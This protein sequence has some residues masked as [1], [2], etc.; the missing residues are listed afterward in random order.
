MTTTT[1]PHTLNQQYRMRF[2]NM[3]NYRLGVWR[4]LCSDYFS[5]LVRPTDAVLDLGAGWCEFI[6]TIQ[7][8]QKWAMDLNPDLQRHAGPNVQ[9]ISQDCSASWP[10]PE[11]SLDAVFTS[12]FF[13]HLPTKTHLEATLR[14][15]YRTLK[16]GGVLICMGPNIRY[17]VGAYWDFWDHHVALTDR[18]LCEVLRLTGFEIERSIARFLPYSMSTGWTPPPIF[19]RM[20]LKLPIVWPFW[21]R[22][23]LVVARRPQ[24]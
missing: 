14:E 18:S 23:F 22:Q 5:S 19:L 11:A 3:T 24:A 10:L 7:A 4:I 12:N 2:E 9:L 17:L 15:A 8:R 20:Y 16:P 21:G 13:E 1:D 6:N